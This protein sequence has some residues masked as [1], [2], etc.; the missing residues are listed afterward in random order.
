MPDIA[1]IRLSDLAGAIRSR[2]D[3]AFGGQT[4]WVLA[5]VANHRFYPQKDHHYFDL[6]EKGPRGIAAKCG[7]VAW[8]E[9]HRRIRAFERTTGRAF[10]NDIHVL[11]CV[12][13][14]FHVA[15]GLKLTLHD[16]DARFTLGQ[17]E[18]QRQRT[19]ERLLREAAADVWMEDGRYVTT[20]ARLRLPPVLQRIAVVASESSAGYED[21]MH[22]L[23]RQAHGYAFALDPYFTRVQ[24][25][26][27]A[28]DLADRL[29]AIREAGIAYDAVVIIRGGGAQTD[30]LIFDEYAVARAVAGMPFP[31]ITGIGHLRNETVTDLMAH[32]VT[33]TP[34]ECAEWIVGRNRI[35]EEAVLSMQRD[36]VLRAQRLLATRNREMAALHLRLVGQSRAALDRRAAGLEEQRRRLT[37]RCRRQLLTRGRE[38]GRLAA[39]LEMSPRRGLERG[40]EA[41]RRL[42]ERLLA[43]LPGLLERRRAELDRTA[44]V[45]HMAS[46]DEVLRRGFALV[47]AE[48]RIR[49]DTSGL[50][51]GMDLEIDMHDAVLTT[52]LTTKTP[53]DGRG[54]DI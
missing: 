5:D 23:A 2:L 21:F 32:T 51:P 16:V 42:R 39:G 50:L 13:V 46:P 6:V 26:G 34:T 29:H 17:L 49:T 41:L 43:A 22:S 44:T 47:R 11:A 4:F 53:R 15:Y 31:V 36:I 24:G 9:G 27:N 40:G 54:N 35:F 33:K 30:L 20:N 8:V 37:E 12:S 52:R 28:Q 1:P 3:D 19:L 7:A 14:D 25:T 18:E 45:V 10:G 48:G 38:L